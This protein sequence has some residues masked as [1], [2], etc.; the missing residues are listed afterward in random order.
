MTDDQQWFLE[1]FASLRSDI[2]QVQRDLDK[3]KQELGIDEPG[4]PFPVR[5]A[6]LEE[7]V[8]RLSVIV[9][10]VATLLSAVAVYITGKIT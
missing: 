4:E 5:L 3:V 2:N 1:Q 8:G 9:P 7:R 6:R 10:A